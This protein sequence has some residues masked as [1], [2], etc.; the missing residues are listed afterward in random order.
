VEGRHYIIIYF[1]QY[2][3]FFDNLIKTMTRP[4]IINEN[5]EELIKQIKLYVYIYQELQAH[6]EEFE[7]QGYYIFENTLKI[8]QLL[9]I[10]LKDE[11]ANYYDSE[12]VFK[13]S[14][15]SAL[16]IEIIKFISLVVIT[17]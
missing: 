5:R 14:L 3:S 9:K 16:I 8:L 17:S 2:L 13:R 1:S 4:K 10:L 15:L 12:M 7:D 11:K 6:I